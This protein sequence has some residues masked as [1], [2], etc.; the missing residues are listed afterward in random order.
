V[1]G[2][3]DEGQ[4]QGM[5]REKGGEGRVGRERNGRVGLCPQCKN[6]CGRQW[7]QHKNCKILLHFG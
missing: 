1:D 5:R 7:I 3:A 4:K 6:S 2:R